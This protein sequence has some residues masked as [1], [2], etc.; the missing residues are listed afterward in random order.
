[1]RMPLAYLLR[2]TVQAVSSSLTHHL[3]AD[4]PLAL[5]LSIS[6]SLYLSISLARANLLHL[7][8]AGCPLD[9]PRLIS[10]WHSEPC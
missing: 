7:L 1:M 5:S 2:L 3:H 8:P 6:P 9:L 10:V 4:C